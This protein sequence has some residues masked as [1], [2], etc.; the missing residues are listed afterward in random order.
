LVYKDDVLK[1]KL[2]E[3]GYTEGSQLF[4]YALSAIKR[5]NVVRACHNANPL[6]FNC[7]IMKI[8]QDYSQYLATQVGGLQHSGTKFHGEWMGENLAYM[9]GS[10]LNIN[11]ETPTNMWYNEISSYNFNNPGFSSGTGH[12][13]QVVWKNS[14]EFGIGLYCQNNK[15]FMTGNYYPGGNFGYN[16]DYAKNVQNLQ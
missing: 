12:F 3:C 13:T 11:G 6:M 5:H 4:N 15:C 7:E 9:G 1:A 14:K 10:N 8:S 16:N 2:K